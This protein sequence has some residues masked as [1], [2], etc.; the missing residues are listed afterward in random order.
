MS[1]RKPD[2]SR[3]EKPPATVP[4]TRGDVER[5]VAA[6][7]QLVNTHEV[8]LNMSVGGRL[9][10]VNVRPGDTV[11]KGQ[12]LAAIDTS[13][14]QAKAQTEYANFVVAQTEY[15][16]TVKAPSA[17]A[18]RAARSSLA[19]AQAA[20]KDLQLPPGENEV[21][22]LQAKLLNAEAALKRAQAAYDIAYAVNPAGIGGA[23]E[24]LELE[25][26]TN[27]YNAAK[28]NYDKAFE[29]PKQ[30]DVQSAAAKIAA[31]QADLAALT[32]VSE[33]IAEAKAKLD[34]AQ[35][36]WQQAQAALDKAV[37]TAPMDGVVT[38]VSVR[39]GDS[40][41]AGQALMVLADPKAVE[42]KASVI[43][44]DLPAVRE[45]QNVQV[46]LDA[47]PEAAVQGKVRRI[48]PKRMDGDRP[49]YP[50]YITFDSL[51]VHLAAGMSVDAS[52]IIDKVSNA[53]RLPRA[54]VR[55]G[56]GDTATVEVWANGRREKRQVKVGLRGDTYV[57]I[58]DGLSEG[59]EVVG[60]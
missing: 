32:P 33:T 7:G 51:P 29:K 12:R 13:D 30:G 8:A 57:E 1:A 40:V 31:A 52:I 50:V 43:E 16:Q 24:G 42:A 19:S 22:D 34:R 47:A 23:P 37:L 56:A 3:V 54:L 10:E 59:E 15:S 36:A 41:S 18:L 2:P 55:A 11:T 48:V 14:L 35:L 60:E 27:D 28:A 21:A 26:A 58:V 9:S 53:L 38:E 49:L 20:Y 6:P 17:A 45:G 46:F 4:V 25:K 39:Q 44:E 5:T